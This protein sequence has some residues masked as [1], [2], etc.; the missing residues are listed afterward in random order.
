MKEIKKSKILFILNTDK[1]LL[2]HRIDIA[3]ELIKKNHEVHLGSAITGASKKISKLGIITHP[4]KINRSNIGLIGLF[5]T[6]LSI[7]QLIQDINPDIVHFISIKPVILGCIATKFYRK[8]LN[9]VA[10]ISGLGFIFVDKGLIGNFRR[11]ITCILYK[12]SLSNRNIKVIFQ[13]NT[14]KNFINKI[15]N[16]S[17]EQSIL[18]NGSGVDLK[19]FQP[20][21]ELNYKKVVLMPARI[22]ESKGINEF[23]KSAEKL[24]GLAK[25]I[26]CGDFDYE[27]KDFIKKDVIEYWVRK[28]VIEYIG[29]KENMEKILTQAS[30]IVLPSYRE[31]LPKVL[32]EAAA[33]GIPVI[34]TN[35]PGCRDAII[36]YKTGLLVPK[37][38]FISLSFAIQYLINNPKRMKMMGKQGRLL[39]INK[40]D[41]N[42]IVANHI[43]IYEKLLS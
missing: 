37:K 16:L 11:I 36:E 21:K 3:K 1:F 32:C 10:S 27:A 8:R 30:I 5:K 22:V 9:I 42:K 28:S 17:P 25:F 39:A 41:I 6:G 31:G 7:Y 19:K 20:K 33:C 29:F 14:D 40:F 34:T 18:I 24:K 43:E 4:I 38:E 15:C 2:S 12:V 26:I 13:N 23:I 35:V